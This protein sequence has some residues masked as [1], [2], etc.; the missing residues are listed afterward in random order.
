MSV[1]DEM[2][3]Y[4]AE[5]ADQNQTKRQIQFIKN[6]LK[7]QGLALDLACGSGRHL[8]ALGK[9]GYGVVGLDISL[10]LLKIA[11]SMA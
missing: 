10:K 2:G 7:P 1:F 8:I 9:E 4:W 11:K 6:T 3:M 5:I